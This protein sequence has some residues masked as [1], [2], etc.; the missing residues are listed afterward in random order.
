MVVVAGV[1]FEVEVIGI[2][3]G[4]SSPAF[5]VLGVKVLFYYYC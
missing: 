3:A 1:F 4:S 2:V 5:G